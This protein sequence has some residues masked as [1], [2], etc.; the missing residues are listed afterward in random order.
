M[1]RGIVAL[2][3]LTLVAGCTADTSRR[4]QPDRTPTV[5]RLVAFDSCP[6]ALA[7]LRAAARSS[8]GPWGLPGGPVPQVAS[9]ERGGARTGAGPAAA[10]PPQQPHSATNN[11]EAAADEP[12][13]VKTDGKR[14]VTL[15]GGVLRVVD[16]VRRAPTGRLDLERAARD[17]NWVTGR[18][19]LHGDRALVLAHLPGAPDVLPAPGTD[20]RAVPHPL[21]AGRTGVLLVDLTGTPKVV[22]EYRVDGELVDARKVG[23]TARVVVRSRPRI[24]FPQPSGDATDAER[25]AANQAA[26]DQ[27][28]L[29]DWLPRYEWTD[30]DGR[31]TGQLPCDRLSRPTGHTGT[32]LLNLLSFDLGGGRL[33]D[34]DP[35]G[36]TA[37]GETVY[38]TAASLYVA[39]H[40]GGRAVTTRRLGSG[41]VAGPVTGLHR[42]DLTAPGRPRYVASGSVPG[43]LLNQY[44]LSEWEG[45]LRV[46]TTTD[47]EGRVRG[48]TSS[49]AVYVLRTDGDELR[50]VGMVDG[51]GRGE[52]IFSVRYLGTTGY[53][54]TFRETD[55]LYTLDLRDPTA[56]KVTGELKITGYSGHLQPVGEGRLLGVGQEA[57]G[58]GVRQG[59]LVSL[60]DVA[61]PAKPTRIAH[62]HRPGTY[63]PAEHDPHALLYWPGSGLVVLPVSGRRHV[64]QEALV[65]R[66]DGSRLTEVG[67]I[68]HPGD[69]HRAGITRSLIVGDTLW[70]LSDVGLQATDPTNLAE[71]NWIPAT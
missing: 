25:I 68:A 17:G 66:T 12:D 22:G 42:F 14:I 71:R 3:A 32:A 11:H 30:S 7:D 53:V 16:P 15:T 44:A 39:D 34:G 13:V 9:A 51:L 21:A 23:E 63:S 40:R 56:P 37:E 65:L 55:P 70:T 47:P 35:V 49:S 64:G 36:V 62:H 38:A 67:R 43:H 48:A 6:N 29:E 50:Q 1:R 20:R 10:A 28:P 69:D 41:A 45:H 59:L 57:N 4:D 61:D 8:V 46:A 54:V 27:A 60:F 19:L 52:R 24:A 2:T 18:L 5:L 26:V 58:Q 31:H 33:G